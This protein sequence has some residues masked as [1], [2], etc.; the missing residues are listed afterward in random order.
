MDDLEVTDDENEQPV[1]KASTADGSTPNTN[2]KP[3]SA[4]NYFLK[5]SSFHELLQFVDYFFVINFC[6]S[7]DNNMDSPL[8]TW[9][10][11]GI[12]VCFFAC[13]MYFVLG[14]DQVSCSASFDDI[15]YQLEFLRKKFPSQDLSLWAGI[16]SGLRNLVKKPVEPAVYLLAFDENSIRS[17]TCIAEV[18]ITLA[19]K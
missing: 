18:I 16:I 12:I 17:S 19:T 6:F 14:S 5:F 13:S 7:V 10:I 2:R 1:E 11:I 8:S 3:P 9:I 15:K 4:S